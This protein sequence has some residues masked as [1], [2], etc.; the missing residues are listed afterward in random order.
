MS[1]GRQ[2]VSG[3]VATVFGCTGFL[4]HYIVNE[5]GKHGS[6]VVVPYRGEESSVNALKVMG[7]LGQIVPTTWNIRDKDSIRRAVQHSNVI[8]NCTGRR[9]D[10]RNFKMSE[11]HVDGAQLIAEVFL[12]FLSDD[13]HI[14]KYLFNP[15]SMRI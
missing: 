7:D 13:K 11:V 15:C 1:G 3:I 10:T 12:Y 2:S 4:G 9:W 14:I 5:L 6:Q 8:V